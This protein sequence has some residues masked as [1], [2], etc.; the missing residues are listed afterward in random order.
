[1]T[2]LSHILGP[3]GRLAD[4]IP[5]FTHRAQQ[6]AM[7]AR[8]ADVLESGGVLI[9]EAG[10]G[11]GKTFAYLVPALLSERKVVIS[12][13]TRN[14]QDQLF[15]RDLPLIRRALGVPVTTALLKGRANYLCRHR[16]NLILADSARLDG[17][18]R[19][20]LKQIRD[21]SS[22]TQR[23]DIA[24]LPIPE[25]A[26]IWP[27]VT[28]T[29]DNCLGQDCPEFG[30]CHLVAA[31]REAQDADL[32]VVNHHLFCAD[33]ALKDE[34]FGEI[35]PG[36]DCFIL[37]EAHQL[38]ETAT[39]FFGISLSSRQL[40]DLAH[41]TELEAIRDA[42]DVLALRDRAAHLRRATQDLRLTMGD[43]DRRGPWDELVADASVSEALLSVAERLGDLIAALEIVAGRGKGLDACLERALDLFQRLTRITTGES[44]DTVRWFETL[45]RGLRLHQTPL[46]IADLFRERIGRAGTAWVLT[47]ATLAVGDGFE[48]F[49]R[50]LGIEHAETARWDSPF[51]YARQA[52]W[53]VPRGL[54]QPAE[55]DYNRHVLELACDV[56]D[57]SRGRAFLLF[58]SHRALRE[59]AEG[60]EGRIRYPLLVQGTAPRA[61][62]VERFRAL[63]NA[64]LLGTSSFWEGVDVRG[65]ALSCVLID[66]L[67]F[68]SP[69][70]PVL[71]ARIEALRKAGGNP[72]RDYQL[73]R[74]VIALKQGAGR[75]IRGSEDRGVL[76][77]CDPR[78]LSKSYGQTFLDSLP[79]MA[80]TREIEQV[81]CFFA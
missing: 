7:A 52:L 21:W 10:T 73:P 81:R 51:D 24:E 34:G 62:L 50:Q 3:D 28:S 20:Q 61:E 30:D 36:A 15:H 70:D 38:P 35:L 29:S 26:A 5:G 42:R 12:T 31:R 69:G 49:A 53:F 79:P 17:A 74:A 71:A 43:R 55:P 58:T 45:G 57:S 1:M 8:V 27:E 14:L 54:P 19:G 75:L 46:E 40:L 6:Q 76:V 48:H 59:I 72:F 78:L 39:G 37:D 68:A 47:S 66:R 18:T 64:V 4:Q 2:D 13:G 23:G 56:I 11:T 41:D 63:G 25:D 33:L 44:S 22:V 65:E 16:L 80:R 67:P 77:V 32:V 60:L 9:C